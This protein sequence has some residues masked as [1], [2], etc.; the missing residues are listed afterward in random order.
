MLDFWLGELTPEDWFKVDE[1]LDARIRDRCLP[2]WEAARGG[3]FASG[4]WRR[5]R[6]SRW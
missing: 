4:R 1:A 5:G 2:T 3:A 6:A